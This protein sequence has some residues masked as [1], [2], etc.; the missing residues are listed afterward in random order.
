[1]I[2]CTTELDSFQEYGRYRSFVIIIII[3]IQLSTSVVLLM[4]KYTDVDCLTCKIFNCKH[5]LF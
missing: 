2:R 1:M 3:I 5:L 4:M